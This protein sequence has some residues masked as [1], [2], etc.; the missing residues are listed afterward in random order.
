MGLLQPADVDAARQAAAKLRK[1]ARYLEE[2]Q[3]SIQGG[4]S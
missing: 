2:L 3:E 4:A 1:P